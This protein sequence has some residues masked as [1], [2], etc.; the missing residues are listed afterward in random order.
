MF[1]GLQALGA[2]LVKI[3]LIAAAMVIATSEM[4][5]AKGDT[6]HWEKTALSAG[7]LQNLVN[8]ENCYRNE[9]NFLGCIQAINSLLSY[10]KPNKT[11]SNAK[12]EPL[13]GHGAVTASFEMLKIHDV[14]TIP[15]NKNQTFSQGWEEYKSRR[16]LTSASWKEVYKNTKSKP[17]NIEALLSKAQTLSSNEASIRKFANAINAYLNNAVDPHTYLIPH[18]QMLEM[19]EKPQ[20]E[21]VGIGAFVKQIS[22]KIILEPAQDSPALIAG[23]RYKDVLTHVDGVA[24]SALKLDE[25]LAKIKGSENSTVVL[26]VDRQSVSMN[27]EV[28]RKKVVFENVTS[29]IITESISNKKIGYIKINSFIDDKLCRKF[30]QILNGFRNTGVESV[31]LDLRNNGG[32]SLDQVACMASLYVDKGKL[33]VTQRDTRT[34]Q[35]IHGYKSYYN[36]EAYYA[37][38][39][40]PLVILVNA[41]SASASELLPGSLHAHQ[42][43]LVVGE[44]TYGKGTVQNLMEDTREIGSYSIS[45]VLYARTTSRFHFADGS[46]NQLYGI[47]PDIEVY[48]SPTPTKEEKFA[49]READHYP[50]AVASSKKPKG[51]LPAKV[52]NVKKCIADRRNL[53]PSYQKDLKS[54]LGPDYQLTMAVEAASCL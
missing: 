17:L 45:N 20:V 27:F 31:V 54:A 21:F 43:A 8:Q 23:I 15:E 22:S 51:L 7:H 6:D 34:N 1:L 2:I 4:A 46:S 26:T 16:D 50:N 48:S 42:R 41:P 33:V 13:P 32:G 19:S 29:K 12:I 11:L 10:S 14:Q 5:F 38:G 18:S 37:F 39:S 30:T 35:I 47:Q 25:V 36:A 49:L 53:I 28:V 40:K 52:L 3:F 9:N 44:R 24:V